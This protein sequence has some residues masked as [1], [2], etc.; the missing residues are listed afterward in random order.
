LGFVVLGAEKGEVL[1]MIGNM[2]L[3]IIKEFL[4]FYILISISYL[5]ANKW[6]A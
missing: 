5:Y 1:F 6:R 4:Q 2:N 3:M